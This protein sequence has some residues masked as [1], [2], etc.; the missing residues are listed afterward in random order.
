VIQ[1]IARRDVTATSSTKPPGAK[2]VG[3]GKYGTGLHDDDVVVS[4]EGKPT[5][6]LQALV[7]AGMGAVTGGAPRITG[8]I[9]RGGSTYVVVIELPRSK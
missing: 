7:Q 3:V 4:V 5:P 6:N 2:L 1:A 9:V 8:K